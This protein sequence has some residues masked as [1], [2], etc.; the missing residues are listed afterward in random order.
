MHDE[1]TGQLLHCTLDRQAS[2]NIAPALAQAQ[3][4]L[5]FGLLV[6]PVLLSKMA[7]LCLVMQQTTADALLCLAVM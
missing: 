2:R 5:C 6:K 3:L 7:V 1:K 4:H